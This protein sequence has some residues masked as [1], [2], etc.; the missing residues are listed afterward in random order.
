MPSVFIVAE[1]VTSRRIATKGNQNLRRAG[2]PGRIRNF[3]NEQPF[4]HSSVNTIK[5]QSQSAYIQAEFGTSSKFMM[6][7][8]L[9][10]TG[11]DLISLTQDF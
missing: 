11:A 3:K 1:K 7:K 9:I 8:V 10:D 6:T 2:Y 4:E 5:F